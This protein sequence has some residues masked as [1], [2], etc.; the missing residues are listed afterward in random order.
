MNKLWGDNFYDAVA[1][2]WTNSEQ[3]EDGKQLKRGFAQFIMDPIIRLARNIMDNNKDAVW[4]MLKSLNV[5]IKE[6]DKEKI[7]KDLLK[8]IYQKWLNAADA[9]LEMICLHLPS[10]KKA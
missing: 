2:K 8:H 9:L 7:G 10:P 3:G 1:K 6:V 5:E 4:K